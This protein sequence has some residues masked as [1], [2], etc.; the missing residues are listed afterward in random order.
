MLVAFPV[1]LYVATVVSLFVFVGNRDVFWYN[2]ALNANVAGVI[3]AAVA[4]VPGL[5]DLVA[6]PRDM[7][8]AKATGIRHAGFNVIAL[9]LFSA[10]ALILYRDT[11]ALEVTAPVILGILGLVATTIAGWLGYSMVQ[12]HHVGVRTVADLETDVHAPVRGTHIPVRRGV[13]DR[14]L[15]H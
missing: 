3:M 15:R 13:S 5:I 8:A 12:V 14:F 2:V 9:V 1:A 10:S 11:G 4:A 7:K 6:L